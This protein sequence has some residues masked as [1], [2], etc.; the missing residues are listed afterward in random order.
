MVAVC[1]TVVHLFDLLVDQPDGDSEVELVAL[2]KWAACGAL[3]LLAI[4][5]CAPKVYETWAAAAFCISALKSTAQAVGP[6][7]MLHA[8]SLAAAFV[9][10]GQVRH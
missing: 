3:L 5:R 6:A 7:C 1:F 4:G 10:S 2:I 8:V 9:V